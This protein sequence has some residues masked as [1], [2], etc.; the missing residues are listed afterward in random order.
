MTPFGA[1]TPPCRESPHP[2][3]RC[4]ASRPL[5][6][7]IPAQAILGTTISGDTH[8]CRIGMMSTRSAFS[9]AIG[10]AVA[11]AI[12]RNRRSDALRALQQLSSPLVV[13]IDDHTGQVS[14]IGESHPAVPQLAG[15]RLIVPVENAGLGPAINVRGTL[16]VVSGDRAS[17]EYASISVLAPGRRAAFIFDFH[18]SLVDFEIGRAHV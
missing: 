6:S 2:P 5:E 18:E 4:A 9:V 10:A 3:Y 15:G 16:N 17:D 12:W 14:T 13:P 7:R 8:S 11:A 1:P